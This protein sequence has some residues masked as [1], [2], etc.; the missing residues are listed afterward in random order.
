[1]SSS[2]TLSRA[3]ILIKSRINSLR[4]LLTI[5]T[6]SSKRQQI[7]YSITFRRYV[8]LSNQEIATNLIKL[9][10]ISVKTPNIHSI[11]L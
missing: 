9:S 7:V 2:T 3:L 10:A 8:I 4:S 6:S 1:M 5:I 11:A